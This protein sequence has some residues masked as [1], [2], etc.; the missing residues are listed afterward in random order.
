MPLARNAAIA[1]AMIV[2]SSSPSAPCSPACGLSPAIARRGRAMPKS[3]RSAAAV[4]RAAATIASVVSMA[5]DF[6]QRGMHGDRHHAQLRAGQHHDLLA[7]RA[8][9]CGEEL[10]V[11]GIG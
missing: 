2:V 6:A 1:G 7:V 3:R 4:V 9:Q 5:M 10:G 8:G 11:A